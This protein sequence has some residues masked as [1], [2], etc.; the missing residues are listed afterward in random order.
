MNQ[1]NLFSAR[2]A[3]DEGIAR[4]SSKNSAWIVKAMH[5]LTKMKPEHPE[6]T[7]EEMRVWLLSNGLW[8]P[9]SVHAWG[10]LTRQALRG[11]V[12]EDTGKVKQMWT[13]RSHARR[14]PIWRFV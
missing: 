9:T 10:A 11:G 7:G 3:R 1:P 4:T 8:N 5:L 14:T 12:I 2:Q 13:E 6:A